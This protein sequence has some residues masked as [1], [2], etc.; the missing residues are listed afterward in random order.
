MNLHRLPPIRCMKG[1]S[2]EID[3]YSAIYYQKFSHF[4]Q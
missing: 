1:T 3:I 2:R 4:F